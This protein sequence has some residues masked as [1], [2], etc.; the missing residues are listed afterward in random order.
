MVAGGG[1]TQ[2]RNHRI[3]PTKP[4]TAPAGREKATD[5]AE[6]AGRFS[7]PAG[8]DEGWVGRDPVVPRCSTTGYYLPSLRDDEG[9]P[10][11]KFPIVFKSSAVL[12]ILITGA[13][14]KALIELAPFNSCHF[15]SIGHYFAFL[16]HYFANYCTHFANALRHLKSS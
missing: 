13:Y 3:N 5:A 11:S 1:A 12:R 6:V 2:E 4:A 7:R 15:V 10:T 8:A 14:F 9:N 16:S